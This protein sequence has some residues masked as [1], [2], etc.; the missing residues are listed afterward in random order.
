MRAPRINNRR[1][2]FGPA[3]HTARKKY[4]KAKKKFSKYP[5][6]HNKTNL[7][8]KSKSYKRTIHKFVKEYKYK[9]ANK[10]RRMNTNDPKQ[11]WRF[12]NRLK[13]RTTEN[14]TP[15]IEE[16]YD[17][18]KTIN[19]AGNDDNDF[20]MPNIHDINADLN[21]P[22]TENEIIKCIKC[23]NNGKTPS[24][25]DNILNEYI[26]HTQILLLLFMLNCS[27]V[28]LILALS[29]C[30]GLMVLSYPY[31]RKVILN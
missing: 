20:V 24:P 31:I 3:C 27:I 29:Q 19:S 7:T 17:H 23:L 5:S 22:I 9:Q 1:P 8:N 26:K 13:P 18:F 11:Y 28:S 21:A 14:Q 30:H 6:A 12:L 4:H 10:L 25:T 2:W 16:L 15:S